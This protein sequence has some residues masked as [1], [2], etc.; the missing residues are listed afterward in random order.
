MSESPTVLYDSPEAASIQT[1]TGWVDRHGRFWGGDEHMARWSGATHQKCP[2]CG[3][4]KELR[5]YCEPC[6]QAKQIEKWQA[7]PRE[8]WDGVSMLYSEAADCYFS[9]LDELASHCEETGA[10]PEALRLVICKP[11]LARP[12]DPE[13]FYTDDL[14]EDGD[15]PLVLQEA[16]NTLNNT[17][18]ACVEPISWSPGDT[19]PTADSVTIE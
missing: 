14:P 16:F 12:I 4:I 15:L 8:P 6:R 18:R 10:T 19:A 3:A 9:D 13:D 7:M 2:G 1:V 5:S 11:N 17:I